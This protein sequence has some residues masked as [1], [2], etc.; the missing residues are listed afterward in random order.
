MKN[1]QIKILNADDLDKAKKLAVCAARLTQNGHKIKDLD[2]F[3]DLYEKP[4]TDNTINALTKLPHPTLQKFI[5]INIIIVG[6]SRRFLAQITRHQN[7]VKFMSASL[8]YSNYVD[9]E[10][11]IPE[12]ISKNTAALDL[13]LEQNKR[14][15]TVYK[16]LQEKYN[17]NHDEASYVLPQGMRNVLLISATIYQW[18]HMIAQR[19]CRRNTAETRYIMLQ[20]WKQLYKLDPILF[21]PKTTGPFCMQSNCKEGKFTCGHICEG[22]PETLLEEY[23]E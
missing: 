11:V 7:E 8:Q 1:I 16:A 10:Y 12:N 13:Y 14:A 15:M 20:I 18:K 23:N 4:Y 2:D 19:T 9:A 3:I 17:I 6:A 22:T 5:T 21:A